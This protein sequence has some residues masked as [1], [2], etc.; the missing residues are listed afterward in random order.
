M[1]SILL[2]LVGILGGALAVTQGGSNV[3]LKKSL[4]AS[5]PPLWFSYL[6]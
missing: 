3:E 6:S 4:G 2:Y 1:G 5:V